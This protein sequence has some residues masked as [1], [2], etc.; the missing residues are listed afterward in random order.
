MLTLQ[1]RTQMFFLAYIL[2]IYVFKIV[3]QLEDLYEGD[4]EC[5][6]SLHEL[7]NFHVN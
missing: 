7:L 1:K 2:S 4:G 3:I 6:D 5:P